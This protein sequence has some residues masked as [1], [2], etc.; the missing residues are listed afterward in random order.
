MPQ[1]LFTLSTEP[2]AGATHLV[3]ASRPETV[4]ALVGLFGV[5]AAKL[6][7]YLT[8]QLARRDPYVVE[9]SDVAATLGMSPKEATGALGTLRLSTMVW[10]VAGGL[11]VRLSAAAPGAAATWPPPQR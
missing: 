9:L 2:P 10:P 1:I 5:P 7:H 8:S 6:L 3:D 4:A 11:A